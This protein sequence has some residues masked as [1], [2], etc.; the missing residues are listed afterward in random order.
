MIVY[1]D[2]YDATKVGAKI[3]EMRVLSTCFSYV[4]D[5]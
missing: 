4:S 5:F 3:I 2:S 1:Y